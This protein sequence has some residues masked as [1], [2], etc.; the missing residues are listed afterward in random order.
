MAVIYLF[1]LLGG[2]RGAG[3][4]VAPEHRA[5][6][7]DLGVEGAETAAGEVELTAHGTQAV[8][9]E[10]PLL[11]PHARL[12]QGSRPYEFRSYSI[13]SIYRL[14]MAMAYWFQGLIGAS[15]WLSVRIY[16]G[17]CSWLAAVCWQLEEERVFSLE[18]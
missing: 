17:K 14:W 7:E 13:Y 9:H 18:S 16:G 6:C 8:A 4:P 2:Y 12:T 3:V 5:A 15:Q 10:Q 1:H 11:R